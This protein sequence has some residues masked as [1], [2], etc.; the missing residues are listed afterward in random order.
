MGCLLRR[1]RAPLVHAAKVYVQGRGFEVGQLDP[2]L[3]AVQVKLRGYN[4]V[5]VLYCSHGRLCK[6]KRKVF[7]P[8]GR[9][10]QKRRGLFLSVLFWL[11]NRVLLSS[12]AG[13]NLYI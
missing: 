4:W 13:R 3:V 7:I 9:R 5:I 2:R 11:L 10:L 6:V 8:I 1:K 12:D